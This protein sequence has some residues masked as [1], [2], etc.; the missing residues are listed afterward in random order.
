MQ[1]FA[2]SMKVDTERRKKLRNR[3]D[4]LVNVELEFG[5]SGMMRDLSEVGFALRATMPLRAGQKT[6]F[7]F[8][9]EGATR[10]SGE[11]RIVWVK[12][13]GRV[14][15]I[16]FCGISH[17]AREQIREWLGRADQTTAPEPEVPAIAVPDPSTLEPPREEA[18]S[19]VARAVPPDPMAQTPLG[20]ISP[21][22]FPA[23]A[24]EPLPTEAAVEP[25]T[26]LHPEIA[27][28]EVVDSHL[29]RRSLLTRVIGLLLLLALIA[30]TVVYRHQVGHALIWLGQVI[31]G[32]EEGTRVP[33]SSVTETPI[34]VARVPETTGP[35]SSPA[36]SN[37]SAGSSPQGDRVA[38]AETQPVATGKGIE[39]QPNLLA[40]PSSSTKAPSAPATEPAPQEDRIPALG[41]SSGTATVTGQ[42]EY[43]Q[44]EQI[45]RNRS[46]ETELAVAVRLLWAAVE[47]G[48]AEA[49]VALAGLY[50]DGKGVAR[51]CNQA[52]ILLTAAAR[53]G[54]AEAHKRLEELMR[55]GCR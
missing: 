9:I 1:A 43:Q 39:A 38:P 36:V 35:I 34:L 54:S 50:R 5:N 17:S 32:P 40:T 23:A 21:E 25:L 49:E 51:N 55:N 47:K 27:Y 42:Q 41:S 44:A 16:E 48:N 10:I 29:A 2:P 26:E 6:Q 13:E 53:K 15:G 37:G 22:R 8:S 30:G 24:L 33:Q 7:A 45:L 4:S 31:A 46:G 18:Q 12:E 20:D 52:R 11:G 3:P 19:T 28:S 14:A